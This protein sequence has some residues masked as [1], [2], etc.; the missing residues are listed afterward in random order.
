[1]ELGECVDACAE[2]CF[3]V[4]SE[5]QTREASRRREAEE[6]EVLVSREGWVEIEVH[7]EVHVEVHVEFHVETPSWEGQAQGVR[8]EAEHFQGSSLKDRREESD[9]RRRRKDQGAP[10]QVSRARHRR[11]HVLCRELA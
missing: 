5:G 4:L 10:P 3:G 11:V 1:M 7:G 2:G 6:A 8:A 9:A